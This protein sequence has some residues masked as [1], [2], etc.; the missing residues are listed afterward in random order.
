MI[1]QNFLEEFK[2]NFSLDTEDSNLVFE[3][4]IN[5][6]TL[7]N[8]IKDNDSDFMKMD[9]GDAKAIDGVAIIV[10]NRM[11]STEEDLEYSIETAETLD[12]EFIFT[13][14]KTSNSFSDDKINYFFKNIN[15]FIIEEE[16]SIPEIETHWELK[17]KIYA[18]SNLLRKGNPRCHL[19]YA[20]QS[21]TT[22]LSSDIQQ[23]ID[24]GLELLNSS[25][26]LSDN[27][28]AITFT[29]IGI[30]E[31]QKFYRNITQD[32][33]A[34]ILLPKVLTYSYDGENIQSAYFGLVDINQYIK[35]LFDDETNGVRRVF[36]DN[37]RDFLGIIDNEVNTNM[38]NC[39]KSDNAQLFGILNNGITIIADD[40]KPTGE[41]YTLVNYQIVN[42]CQTSNVILEN[43]EEIKEKSISLP[44][45]LIK[46]TDDQTKTKIVKATNSQTGLKPEQLDSLNAFHKM[47]E[48]YFISVN[49]ENSSSNKYDVNIYYE[50]RTNQYRKSSIIKN[51]IISIPI[52]IKAV[53]SMFKNNPHGVS[54]HYGT[55]ARKLKDKIFLEDHILEA[56]HSSALMYYRVDQ[57]FNKKREFKEYRRMKWHIMMTVKLQLSSEKDRNLDLNNKKLKS[58]SQKIS[59]AIATESKAFEIIEGAIEYLN[60]IIQQN[61]LELEDRKLFER[62]ETTDYIIKSFYLEQGV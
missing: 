51:R 38:E 7:E 34:T 26:Y 9:T 32:L 5:Y 8:H 20:T 6:C 33:E 41:K 55:V 11:I 52:Q 10:N 21:Q 30:K 29:P 16:C 43:I 25:G 15:K 58:L 31:I 12:V 42:G 45:R 50:R 62:K 39:L 37:I 49:R 47:L 24:D 57:F 60:N 23:S 1:V 18:N 3:H 53:A 35:L 46:T 13:Q 48:D 4:F 40:I 59:D 61:S 56:Y 27:E 54:G 17:N 14:S 22:Q 19:Y 44:I 28:N 2:S 36:D